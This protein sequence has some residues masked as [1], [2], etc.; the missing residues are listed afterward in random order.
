MDITDPV[1]PAMTD[2]PPAGRI[3]LVPEVHVNDSATKPLAAYLAAITTPAGHR[4]VSPDIWV[5]FDGS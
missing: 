4:L 2:H 5:S 3:A 1:T